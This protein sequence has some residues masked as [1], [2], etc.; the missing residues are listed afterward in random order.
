MTGRPGDPPCPDCGRLV[1]DGANHKHLALVAIVGLREERDGAVYIEG[2]K[3]GDDALI[4]A[5]DVPRLRDF[6]NSLDRRSA[7]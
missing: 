1:C 3:G 5:G 2:P 4:S 6:L 7:S